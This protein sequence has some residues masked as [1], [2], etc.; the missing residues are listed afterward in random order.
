MIT[1]RNVLDIYMKKNAAS[2]LRK[3]DVHAAMQ[4]LRAQFPDSFMA[5]LTP[6]EG[7]TWEETSYGDKR[8]KCCAIVLE[9]PKA[10]STAQFMLDKLVEEATEEVV[11][12]VNQALLISGETLRVGENGRHAAL[13]S[14]SGGSMRS[15]S[16]P[17]ALGQSEL[18]NVKEFFAARAAKPSDIPIYLVIE[19]YYV[20]ERR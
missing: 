13:I 17:T 2:A 9:L 6:V 11:A 19:P 14:I 18:N 16:P 8:R 20:D 3:G 4:R 5:T 7:T 15:W 12:R 10:L 1:P